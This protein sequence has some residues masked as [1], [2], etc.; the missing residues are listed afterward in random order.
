[1]LFRSHS[2]LEGQHAFLSASKHHWLRYSDEKLRDTY[3]AYEAVA[4]GTKLH[5]FAKN[6]IELGRRM[7]K[8][9][10]VF[11]QYIND[12]I[13]YRM[14]PEQVLYYSENCFGTADSISF[15]KN[16]LRIHDLK[17]GDTPASFE[18]LMIYAALFC[19]EYSVKP[20]DIH[21]ELRIYQTPEV[22]VYEPEAEE[23]LEIMGR[24]IN[25][26]K[27]IETIKNEV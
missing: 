20:V 7:P 24:I 3:Y 21:I 6:A 16:Y 22:I 1:M 2:N 11:N 9:R 15:N 26:D 19:L 12:A 25:A 5:E 13:G 10:D 4:L 23:I 17:T 14:T 27:I 18:Q 8:G